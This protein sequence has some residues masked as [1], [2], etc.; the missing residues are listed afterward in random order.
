MKKFYYINDYKITK[1]IILNI[2]SIPIFSEKGIN[3]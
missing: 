1:I 2:K 3:I